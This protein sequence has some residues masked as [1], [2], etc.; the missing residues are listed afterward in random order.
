MKSGRGLKFLTLPLYSH[1]YSVFAFVFC[2]T[3]A[4]SCERRNVS[5]IHGCKCHRNLLMILSE[6]VDN[7]LN[8][9]VRHLHHRVYRFIIEVHKC[10]H[11][12]YLL[13]NLKI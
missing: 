11:N 1:R 8:Q 6:I 5:R 9:S 12:K 7:L 10:H 3:R 4:L 13:S 2:M